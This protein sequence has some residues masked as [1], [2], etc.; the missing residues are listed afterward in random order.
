MYRNRFRTRAESTGTAATVASDLYSPGAST[1][2][3][4][5]ASLRVQRCDADGFTRL[6]IRGK[7]IFV[8]VQQNKMIPQKANNHLRTNFIIRTDFL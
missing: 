5:H 7:I 4:L 1:K 2:L 8:V 6:V 3:R